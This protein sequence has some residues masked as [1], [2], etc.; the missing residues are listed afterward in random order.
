MQ[1]EEISNKRLITKDMLRRC[2]ICLNMPIE[3]QIMLE[4][5]EGRRIIVLENPPIRIPSSSTTACK[6]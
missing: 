5:L 1:L 3:N 6:L 2:D 4:N